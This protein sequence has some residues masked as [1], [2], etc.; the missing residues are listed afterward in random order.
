MIAQLP[1]ARTR[2]RSEFP[3][4]HNTA[5]ARVPSRVYVRGHG[6]NAH[7]RLIVQATPPRTSARGCERAYSQQRGACKQ[8]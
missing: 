5:A 7:G 4:E 1:D 6:A 3:P 2:I 8:A